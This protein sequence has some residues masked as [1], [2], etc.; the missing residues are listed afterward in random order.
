M[1]ELSDVD[2][3][4]GRCPEMSHTFIIEIDRRGS[5]AQER[6]RWRKPQSHNS[7]SVAG[8]TAHVAQEL[9]EFLHTHLLAHEPG[10]HAVKADSSARL[11]GAQGPR[12]YSVEMY[13]PALGGWRPLAATTPSE[14]IPKNCRVHVSVNDNPK[15]APPLQQRMT[16]SSTAGGFA[17]VNPEQAS[18]EADGEMLTLPWRRFDRDLG[19]GGGDVFQICGR[20]MVIEDVS[21]SSEGTGLFTWDGSVLLAKYLEHQA[22]AMRREF[23][24]HQSRPQCRPTSA[25]RG[26]DG[27]IERGSC[28]MVENGVEVVLTDLEYAL[29]NARSN[30]RRNASSLRAVGSTVNAVELDWCHPLPDA[31]AG[32]DSFDLILAADVVWL[33]ELVEPLVR[34]LERLTAGWPACGAGGS[35][36]REPKSLRDAALEPGPLGER[37]ATAHTDGRAQKCQGA[38]SAGPPPVSRRLR[39]TR[40]RQR[41]LLAYQWRSQRTG[42]SLFEELESA[43]WVREIQPEECHQDYLPSSNLCLFELV[44]R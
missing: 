28:P 27:S 10:R 14:T 37:V 18:I 8:D 32:G 21:N 12:L 1:A 33:D 7:S 22:V 6:L 34:T 20:R 29:E 36:G 2:A 16:S 24:I 31:F 40:I 25:A 39:A 30:I 4:D 13:H 38:V 35:N 15:V 26:N 41:V 19:D 3:K 9:L 17:P 23:D 11:L 44:R 42:D 5:Q 43:F